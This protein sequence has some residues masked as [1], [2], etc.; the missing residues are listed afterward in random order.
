[1]L[2]KTLLPTLSLAALA[3]AVCY[4]QW[5]P[6]SH[7]T[8]PPPFAPSSPSYDATVAATGIVEAQSENIDVGSP[9]P[10][11]V[12]QVFV[13]VGQRVAKGAPLFR[14]DDRSRKAELEVLEA[15]LLLAKAK[16]A[17]L[18]AQPRPEQ[19]PILEARIRY[20][21]A[22]LDEQ[23][24]H[25]LRTQ[26]IRARGAG[27]DRQLV[28]AQ[29]AKTQSREKL[30]EMQAE[31][32]L[33][34]RGA[35]KH[36]LD[37][38]ERTVRQAESERDQIRTELDRLTVRARLDTVVLKINVHPGEFIAALR[39]QRLL[40]LGNI[41]TLHVRVELDELD[42]PRFKQG[43]RC[44]ASIPGSVV[45]DIPLLFVRVEPLVVPKRSLRAHGHDR[46]DTRVL[47]VVFA[48][49]SDE[50]ALFVGQQLDVFIEAQPETIA[51]RTA[52]GSR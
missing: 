29:Q 16:L 6:T 38:A 15:E 22:E 51:L 31:Y 20:A 21:R 28:H 25:L 5:V 47:Q 23:E 13:K 12:A 42:I 17:R 35:W 34:R 32:D 9:V 45:Q 44:A 49:E 4:V 19:L 52:R 24:D 41:E 48:V 8:P 3:G 30:A 27:T 50:P 26:K 11:V 18:R 1:M 2:S 46:V 10:G 39:S 43:A 33:L 36:D 40:V 37:I 14:L 7:A